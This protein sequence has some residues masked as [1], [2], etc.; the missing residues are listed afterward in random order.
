MQYL[1]YIQYVYMCAYYISSVYYIYIVYI[2]IFTTT[3]KD[4]YYSPFNLDKEA[5]VQRYY[6]N[7]SRPPGGNWQS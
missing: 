5:E 6:V 4:D 2:I 7:H 1:G 3:L